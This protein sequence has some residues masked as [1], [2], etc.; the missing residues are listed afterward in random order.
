MRLHRIRIF[1]PIFPFLKGP[2]CSDRPKLCGRL[3]ALRASG[4]NRLMPNKYELRR[5]ALKATAGHAENPFASPQ[6]LP[7]R[8]PWPGESP[9]RRA[10]RGVVVAICCLLVLITLAVFAQTVGHGFVNCDDNEYVY[11]NL[12][13][14]HGLN[15]ASAWWAVTQAHSANWHPLS[16]MSHMIDWQLFGHW[17]ADH[18]HYV[19]S[20]PGGHHLVNVLLHAVNVVLLFLA[21]QAM[22]GATWPR[23]RSWRS[24]SP[25]ILFMSNPWPGSPSA[26]TCSAACSSC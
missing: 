14:Q 18:G 26:R 16:W 2:G 20:W 23:R 15:P 1:L 9:G 24:S 3:A 25:S 21:L 5:R 13:I 10:S 11:D 8:R 22:T 4:Q 7:S 17:D 19:K 12:H 6:S